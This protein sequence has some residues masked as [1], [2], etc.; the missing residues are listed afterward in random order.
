M[1]GGSENPGCPGRGLIAWRGALCSP[2][3]K[4]TA[5]LTL[6]NRLHI[7]DLAVREELQSPVTGPFDIWLVMP[8]S[9]PDCR[10][11]N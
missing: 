4:D 5:G 10:E 1:L 8:P 9:R 3:R 2:E 11:R 7:P 6:L